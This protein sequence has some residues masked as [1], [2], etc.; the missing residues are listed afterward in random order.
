MVEV[1]QMLNEMNDVTGTGLSFFFKDCS[2]CVSTHDIDS[3]FS[4]VAVRW[5]T[6]WTG[7]LCR[8]N[9]KRQRTTAAST[10]SVWPVWDQQL[11]K[12]A[13][14]QEETSKLQRITSFHLITPVYPDHC[15]AQ[16]LIC[17]FL[18]WTESLVLSLND[19]YSYTQWTGSMFCLRLCWSVL[20][21]YHM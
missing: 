8:V 17:V 5:G 3:C 4:T 11:T 15:D 2:W 7:F 19:F 21:C 13:C 10:P 16:L 20:D 14:L 6:V 9:A 1:S 18:H 12:H